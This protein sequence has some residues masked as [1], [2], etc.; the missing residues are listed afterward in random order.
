[1]DGY[2]SILLYSILFY[3]ILFYSRLCPFTT[4]SSPPPG[5][6]NFLS[7][8]L[9][10]SMPLSVAPAMSSLQ[11]RSGLP[12]YLTRLICHSVLLIVHLLSFIRA[13]CP[14][15]FHFVLFT[16]WTMSVTLVLCLM[17]VLRI[18]SFSLTVSIFLSI[19][20]WLV[21]SVFTNVRDHVWRPYVIAGKTHWLNTFLFRLM[22]R[23]LSRK[24]SLYFAKPLHPAFILI[25]ASC[26]VVFHGWCL[27]QI[28]IV[29]RLLYF[30]P[31]YLYGVCCVNICHK[32][33]FSFMYLETNL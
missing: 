13:M 28:F 31:V 3:S 22:G 18:L 16:Y 19:A 21:S 8:F 33:T 27:S 20:R 9:S 7:P 30:C 14:A 11:R 5:S 12:T 29:S 32:F 23:W 6:S 15:H 1:M 26:F 17:M 24:I 2:Y 4:E 25:K 10:L